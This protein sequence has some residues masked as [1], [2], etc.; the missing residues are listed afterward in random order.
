MVKLILT[1]FKKM[2]KFVNSQSVSGTEI[3]DDPG[4]CWLSV[5]KHRDVEFDV[6]YCPA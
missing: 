3:H 4:V 2:V 1:N 6:L 5:L